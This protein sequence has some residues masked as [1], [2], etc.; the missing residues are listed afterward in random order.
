[1]TRIRSLLEIAELTRRA[2]AYNARIRNAENEG[3]VRRRRR[4]EILTEQDAKLAR[5]H[6]CDTWVYTGKCDTRGQNIPAYRNS[7]AGH[8]R[9]THAGAY[10]AERAA[11][12][13]EWAR[14]LR[15]Q[16]KAS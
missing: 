8:M 4:H 2:A 16:G 3:R 13:A 12:Q 9:V 1:M 5:C 7:L 10:E 15:S 14:G 11:K 6:L